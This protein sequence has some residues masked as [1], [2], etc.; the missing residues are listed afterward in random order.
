VP[1]KFTDIQGRDW[2]LRITGETI[3]EA[4]SRGIDLDVSLFMDAAETGNAAK[5]ASFKLLGQ[6]LELCWL[7]CKHNSRV[8]AGT[9]DESDFK[10]AVCGK[11]LLPAVLATAEALAE[12]FGLEVKLG[13]DGAVNP[14]GAGGEKT[15][16][17][18]GSAG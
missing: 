12:C 7:A 9:V 2:T 8:I 14:P 1:K 4:A 11:A 13:D 3:C 17:P 10:Q 18:A 15:A 5:L 6:F 16:A